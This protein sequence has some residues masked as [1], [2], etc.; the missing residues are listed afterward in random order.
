MREV[1]I[2][3]DLPFRRITQKLLLSR[4]ELHLGF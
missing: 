2:L 3:F 4:V 1:A